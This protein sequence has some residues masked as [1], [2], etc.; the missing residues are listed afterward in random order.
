[1]WVLGTYKRLSVPILVSIDVKI[2]KLCIVK[3]EEANRPATIFASC[4][5]ANAVDLVVYTRPGLRALTLI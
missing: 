5:I 3:V 2:I 1:M 4:K